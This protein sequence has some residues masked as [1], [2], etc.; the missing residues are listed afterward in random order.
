MDDVRIWSV[1]SSE[2]ATQRSNAM[3]P[4]LDMTAGLI[5]LIARLHFQGRDKELAGLVGEVSITIDTS[6]RQDRLSQIKGSIDGGKGIG[7]RTIL[8]VMRHRR[9]LSGET[10][11]TNDDDTRGLHAIREA[12]A[13]LKSSGEHDRIIA[14][15]ASE[16]R[17]G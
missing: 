6:P 14:Q 2:N 4:A 16:A 12:V 1:G 8:N 10:S 17:A 7:E 11:D 5:R 9:K 15:E 3:P 13:T